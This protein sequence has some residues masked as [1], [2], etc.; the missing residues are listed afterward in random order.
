M[1]STAVIIAGLALLGL[2]LGT[3]H[4]LSGAAGTARGA[5]AFLPLW[6]VGSGINMYVGLR[7]GR[8]A[9]EEIPFLFLVF[10]IPVAAAFAVW[11]M[12][13]PG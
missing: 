10:A 5:L 6:A 12:L 3:A 9:A 4:V 11:W 8:S 2:C 1:H 13:A 7:G